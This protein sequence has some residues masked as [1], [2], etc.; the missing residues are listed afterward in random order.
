MLPP[1]NSNNEAGITVIWAAF[2]SAGAWVYA[3]PILI[4]AVSTFILGWLGACLIRWRAA[5]HR[6]SGI[7]WYAFSFQLPIEVD[8]SGLWLKGLTFLEPFLAIKFTIT[9]ATKRPIEI[10]GVRG[11]FNI[12]GPCNYP[13]RLASHYRTQGIRFGPQI[14]S[15]EI[16]IE[17]PVTR[18]TADVVI[19]T[20]KRSNG[21]VRVQFSE[22]QLEGMLTLDVS[23]IVPLQNCYLDRTNRGTIGVGIGIRGPMDLASDQRLGKLDSWFVALDAQGRPVKL[24]GDGNANSN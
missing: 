4:Y 18:E 17:Q 12:N 14:A 13:A 9:N 22:V 7:D 5:K 15:Y 11:S 24:S 20:L 3:H 6:G 1:L 10:T 19:E 8:N 2:V 21:I 16:S 23:N